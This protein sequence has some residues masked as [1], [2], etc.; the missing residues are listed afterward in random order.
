VH[1]GE[2]ILG[3]GLGDSV[4]ALLDDVYIVSG[5]QWRVTDVEDATAMRLFVESIDLLE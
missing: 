4:I 1:L 5:G 2:N 3:K